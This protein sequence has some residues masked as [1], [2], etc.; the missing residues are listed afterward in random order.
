MNESINNNVENKNILFATGNVS[1]EG[2]PTAKCIFVKP[3][4]NRS[5]E[6]KDKPLYL[7][8]DTG[9]ESPYFVVTPNVLEALGR[10]DKTSLGVISLDDRI[11]VPMNNSSIIKITDEYYA[12]NKASSVYEIEEIKSDPI[13]AQENASVA[14]EIKNSIT[15]VSGTD[16]DFVCNDFYSKNDIYKIDNNTFSLLCSDVSFVGV[17][18]DGGIYAHTNNV[19]DEVIRVKESLNK[20]EEVPNESDTVENDTIESKPV[21]MPSLRFT[22]I[23]EKPLDTLTTEN[24]IDEVK[25]G[26]PKLINESMAEESAKETSSN[27][28]DDASENISSTEEDYAFTPE[29]S[30]SRDGDTLATV[31]QIVGAV[32]NRLNESA[33]ELRDKDQIINNLKRELESSK[34]EIHTMHKRLELLEQ[35]N[36]AQDKQ[37]NSMK[38]ENIE[39]K[40]TNKELESANDELNES[41]TDADSIEDDVL[42]IF[43]KLNDYLNKG[44]ASGSKG[45]GTVPVPA[46]NKPESSVDT[47]KN[48]PVIRCFSFENLDAFSEA[49][50]AVLPVYNDKSHLFKH[51]NGRYYVFLEKTR[52]SSVDFNKTCNILSEYGKKEYLPDSSLLFFTEH[53]DSIIKNR[54]IQVMAKL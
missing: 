40:N 17:T 35:K 19:N 50:K 9:M 49:A 43:S 46:A 15:K 8:A 3:G 30:A 4:E 32:K 25:D 20:S 26:A 33:E 22:N 37:I 1:Q 39:L 38:K 47:Q 18:T 45:T 52:C 7:V 14:N 34:V 12:C 28:F 5:D 16:I 23:E 21:E 31:S 13:K 2:Y 44:S 27:F 53:M 54:A 51:T 29:T 10:V 6:L 11:L 41:D 42:N 24:S 36:T 48:A